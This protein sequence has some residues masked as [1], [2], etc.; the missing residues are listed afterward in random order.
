MTN[1][2]I[3]ELTFK[4]TDLNQRVSIRSYLKELLQTLWTEQESFSG[5]RPFGNSGWT[6]DIYSCLVENNLIKGKLDED[7]YLDSYDEEAAEK[8]MLKLIE[9]L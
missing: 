5:K 3:L 6:H 8:L 4:S 1:E 9:S 7:G 2:E